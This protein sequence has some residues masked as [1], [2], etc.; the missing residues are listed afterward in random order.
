MKMNKKELAKK[1]QTGDEE[2]IGL[3]ILI[4]DGDE[5]GEMSP[6][7]YATHVSSES[8]DEPHE[9]VGKVMEILTDSG[10]SEEDAMTACESIFNALDL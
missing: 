9:D 3:L 5:M 8:Y 10:L 2:A 6:E 1:A 7:E 4:S